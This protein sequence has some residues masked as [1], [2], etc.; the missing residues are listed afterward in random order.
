M[1]VQTNIQKSNCSQPGLNGA[2]LWNGV[3]QKSGSG[4]R[5]KLPKN[6]L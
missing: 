1:N 6:Y 2:L 5:I 4:R 3:Q